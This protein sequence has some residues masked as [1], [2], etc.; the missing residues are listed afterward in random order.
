MTILCPVCESRETAL[1]G[2]RLN[3]Y[4][5]TVCTHEFTSVPK[6]R[7][8]KY[9]KDYFLEEHKNWFNNP[10]PRLF[11][12]IYRRLLGLSNPRDIK[13]LDVGCGD[14]TFLNYILARGVVTKLYGI[15]LAENRHPNIRFIK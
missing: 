1:I 13:L 4:R 9:S 5:C 10:D 15:D 12:F 3:I 11:D 8:E 2:S 6:E 14:G 7:Q